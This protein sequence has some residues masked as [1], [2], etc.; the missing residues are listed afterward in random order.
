[1]LALGQLIPICNH[2][3]GMVVLSLTREFGLLLWAKLQRSPSYPGLLSLAA[4][5]KPP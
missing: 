4:S 2:H 3:H 5:L 1:M